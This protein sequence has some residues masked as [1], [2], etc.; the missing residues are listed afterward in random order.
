MQFSDSHNDFLTALA[1]DKHFAYLAK[2]EKCGVKH[3]LCSAFTSEMKSEDAMSFVKASALFVDGFGNKNYCLHIEDLGFAKT[4]KQLE[5]VAALRPFSCSLCWNTDNQFAGG[6][7]GTGSLTKIG[8]W[9][10]ELLQKNGIMLDTAHLNKKSF[11]SVAKRTTLPLFC[12]HTGLDFVKKSPRNL[13]VAQAKIIIDSGGY[14]GLF[15]SPTFMTKNGKMTSDT[16]ARIVFETMCKFGDNNFG[17]GS[18]FFGIGKPTGD[19]FDYPDFEKVEEKLLS[20]GVGK[21]S[22]DKFFCLNFERFAGKMH[23]Q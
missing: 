18:D 21:K 5:E 17:L 11:Y 19:I 22:I 16:F 23:V 1:K 2:C 15:L 13:S 4:R 20:F 3:L 9:A 8:M 7:F 12:S 6:N 10:I 14:F